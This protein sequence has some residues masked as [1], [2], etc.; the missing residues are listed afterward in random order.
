MLGPR[1]GPG[2]CPLPSAL[3][4]FSLTMGSLCFPT[5]GQG[6]WFSQPFCTS[7]S[8]VC[9]SVNLNFLH[10]VKALELLRFLLCCIMFLPF[11]RLAGI[12]S[13]SL[14]EWHA[15][16]S[17][18]SLRYMLQ[19]IKRTSPAHTGSLKRKDH[20]DPNSENRGR[21]LKKEKTWR[22]ASP[23]VSAG[24]PDTETP[25]ALGTG[26]GCHATVPGGGGQGTKFRVT[27]QKKTRLPCP[28][29]C[30]QTPP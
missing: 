16:L 26:M 24:F 25:G 19:H 23:A 2:L 8:L 11:N 22:A 1:P 28:Q 6:I 30:R 4:P 14:R 9:V 20:S 18:I 5:P 21:P 29:T 7:L 13:V 3:C 17:L 15:S 10:W 27:L 12:I